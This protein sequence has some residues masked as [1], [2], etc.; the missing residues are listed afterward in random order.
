MKASSD[1]P[2]PLVKRAD[3]IVKQVDDDWVVKDSMSLDYFRLDRQQVAILELLDGTRSVAEIRAE[4]IRAMPDF[5]PS[6]SDIRHFVDDM[7]AKRLVYSTRTGR[8]A[9][10]ASES[11]KRRRQRFASAAKQLLY[12]RLPGFHPRKLLDAID[13]WLRAG[14]GGWGVAIAL[15]FV[16]MVWLRCGISYDEIAGQLPTATQLN[17]PAMW[18]LGWL[19]IGLAKLA[20]EIGHA[21]ACRRLGGECN[22]IGVAFL[23]FSPCLYCDVSDAAMFA[24]RWH[25]I[26]VGLAGVYVELIIASLAAVAWWFLE[27]SLLRNWCFLLVLITSVSSIAFNLNPLLRLDGYYI[28]SDWLG[29][30]NL[31]ERSRRMLNRTMARHLCG[32]ELPDQA[33]NVAVGRRWLLS[34]AL[35]SQCYQWLFLAF[36]AFSL[37]RLFEP[38]GLSVAG[39]LLGLAAVAI[40]IA[41]AS[42]QF[43]RFVRTHGD[44]IAYSRRWL[45]TASVSVVVLLIAFFVPL[46]LSVEVPFVAEPTGAFHLYVDEPGRLEQVYVRPGAR[47]KAGQMIAR[48]D[49]DE[50]RERFRAAKLS[51]ELK[52]VELTLYR[53]EGDAANAESARQELVSLDEQCRQQHRRLSQLYVVA[54]C[55]GTVV[56]PARLLNNQVDGFE[57][58]PSWSGSP[59]DSSN[60]GAFLQ[61]GTEIAAVAAETRYQLTLAID[62]TLRDDFLEGTKVRLQLDSLP[63]RT[64]EG[65]ISCV[66]QM[67]DDATNKITAGY[68]A[69]VVIDSAE[70]PLV[71]GMNGRA[72][73]L[74][75]HRTAAEWLWRQVC[76]NV[77]GQL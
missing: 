21:L 25:R 7:L 58:L 62:Q 42:Q 5:R 50:V 12:I 29:V 11:R 52:R 64:V 60:N 22:E 19:T 31:R 69:Q 20:H 61:R 35:L 54:P 40:A 46:P 72:R 48:L 68:R 53:A 30:P 45:A 32:V 44:Q 23:V 75:T 57:R 49:N 73:T 16:A 55:D 47:V 3:L 74:V 66:S 65:E 18:A 2:L 63:G 59:L 76:I 15:A 67:V 34:Y 27:P 1:R 4:L 39:W 14:F 17:T 71:A 13:P 51:A 38:Y 70:L 6:P 43:I 33:T 77:N 41:S 36:V 37:S 28:L 8:G 26:A 10:F 9:F 56:E 24:N